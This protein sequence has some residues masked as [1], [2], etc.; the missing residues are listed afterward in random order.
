MPLL[1][2]QRPLGPPGRPH[3]LDAP[4]SNRNVQY[5]DRYSPDRGYLGE[6]FS[7]YR[8]TGWRG[9][10]AV[11]NRSPSPDR[12]DPYRMPDVDHWRRDAW[13]APP[14]AAPTWHESSRPTWNRELR[15]TAPL[16]EPSIHWKQAHGQDIARSPTLEMCVCMLV[17]CPSLL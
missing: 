7:P 1:S 12:Y 16:L 8:D 15:D 2:L 17:P 14:A 5:Y 11:Y 13:V 9:E 4:G 6:Y 10:R 3:P